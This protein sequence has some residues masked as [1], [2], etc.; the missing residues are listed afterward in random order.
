MFF[1][2]CLCDQWFVF[3]SFSFSLSLSLFFSRFV[4]VYLCDWHCFGALRRCIT[5]ELSCFCFLSPINLTCVQ[6][7]ECIISNSTW[8]IR[9]HY[10]IVFKLKPTDIVNYSVSVAFVVRLFTSRA[11]FLQWHKRTENYNQ[12]KT[13][14]TYFNGSWLAFIPYPPSNTDPAIN[15]V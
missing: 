11:V 5:R 3:H 4:C 6:L 9:H 10:F 12:I 2:V 15:Y 8:S 1:V 7:T 14:F 13:H